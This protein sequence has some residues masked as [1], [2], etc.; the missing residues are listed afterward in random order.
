MVMIINGEVVPDDDPRAIARRRQ[1]ASSS[2]SSSGRPNT[3][4][5][6]SGGTQ[7]VF[8]F[9]SSGNGSNNNRGSGPRPS[10]GNVPSWLAPGTPLGNINAQ[11]SAHVQ[12]FELGGFVIYPIV[13]LAAALACF[14]F[15]IRGLIVVALV[16]FFSQPDARTGGQ[17]NR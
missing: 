6:S 16:V 9:G 3:Y 17:Q 5:S 14:I 11:L 15:G 12:A 7:G 1:A 4:A 13:L 8:G 10:P 2:S